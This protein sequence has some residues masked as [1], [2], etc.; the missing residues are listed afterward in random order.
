MGVYCGRM[1]EEWH[2]A[3]HRKKIG[4]NG[5]GGTRMEEETKMGKWVKNK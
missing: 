5:G 4:I 3:I 2:N 1:H